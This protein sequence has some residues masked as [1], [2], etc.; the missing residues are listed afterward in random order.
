MAM[1]KNAREQKPAPSATRDFDE[2]SPRSTEEAFRAS[3]LASQPGRSSV[4]GKE[5]AAT[6]EEEK[7]YEEASRV[8]SEALYQGD[9][10]E[11]I[12]TMLN[13]EE[14]VGSVAKA[15]A[16]A[17]TT[18][19]NEYD[20]DEVVIPQLTEETTER[21]IELYEAQTDDEFSEQESQAA[22]GA[23]WEAVIGAYGVESGQ[24]AELTQGLDK[25]QIRGYEDEYQG[26]LRSASGEA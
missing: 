3:Q 24:Y 26:M 7:E 16:F 14:K 15:V 12:S 2:N 22:L 11:G 6:P 19:D 8:V 17:I 23:A 10:A 13:P 25:S 4:T 9:T 21:I 5:E 20:F 1:L 18:L